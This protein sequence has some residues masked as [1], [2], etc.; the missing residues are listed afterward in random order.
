VERLGGKV[1]SSGALV[2]RFA[3]RWSPSELAD[4]HFAARAL[5]E[6]A[7]REMAFAVRAAGTGLSE[8]ALQARV[9]AAI[10]AQG[11]VSDHPPIVA[12]GINTANPH[13]E[14]HAGADAVLAA[15]DVVLIDLW[16]SRPG[17][18]AAD[19]TW[20][21]FAGSAPPERVE[22]VWGTV[23]T[24]R[25]AAVAL[26][27]DRVSRGKAVAGYEADQAARTVIERAGLG[28]WFVHRTGHSIDRDLHGS[29]PNLDDY[30]THDDRQLVAGVGFSV[31][32]GVY[33]EGEFGVRSE[34]TMVI[35]KDDAQV[36]PAEVQT[37]LIVVQ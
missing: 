25:D 27:R 26:V 29:G 12:F 1:V 8:T 28:D 23:R 17:S 21:G 32:P 22:R 34:V 2:S 10:A 11:L 33:I 35:G 13:Y 18:V 9:V 16:G 7:R 15:G 37:G 3:A 14:P 30:E 6:I 36:T 4:H 20:M 19:Q 5:A 24:A 31:E